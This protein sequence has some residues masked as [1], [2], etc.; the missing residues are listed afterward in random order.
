[1]NALG[2]CSPRN[3]IWPVKNLSAGDQ[4]RT[5]YADALSLSL[6]HLMRCETVRSINDSGRR[7]SDQLARWISQCD[8]IRGTC[9]ANPLSAII[10]AISSWT[11]EGSPRPRLPIGFPE[12]PS[13]LPPLPVGMPSN[14]RVRLVQTK[15]GCKILPK[16]V[17]EALEMGLQPII[18]LNMYE[19]LHQKLLHTIQSSTLNV[20]LEE[21]D[22]GA[23]RQIIEDLMS[24]SMQGMTFALALLEQQTLPG[25]KCLFGRHTFSVSDL[26]VLD[27]CHCGIQFLWVD[28][29]GLAEAIKQ[30]S[31][32]SAMLQKLDISKQKSNN[33]A[34]ILRDNK[35]STVDQLEAYGAK[36][37]PALMSFLQNKIGMNQKE[38]NAIKLL[39]ERKKDHIQQL[40]LF[41][42]LLTSVPL[43]K[44][45]TI[46][47]ISDMA[48]IANCESFREKQPIVHQGETGRRFYVILEGHVT[49]HITGVG[50]VADLGP[51]KFFGEIALLKD[52]PR[53]AT[54]IAHNNGPV[55]C[56]CMTIEREAFAQAREIASENA[57]K[58]ARLATAQK[59]CQELLSSFNCEG[60]TIRA[61]LQYRDLG[62]V[63]T[64][65]V[66]MFGNE[67]GYGCM[68]TDSGFSFDGLWQDGLPC[69]AGRFESAS[70]P[71]QSDQQWVR[72]FPDNAVS[73]FGFCD[74]EDSTSC[75][76]S[77]FQYALCHMHGLGVPKDETKAM[78]ILQK[79]HSIGH[80]DSSFLIA[81]SLE[82]LENDGHND[83]QASHA[84]AFQIFSSTALKGH[85][86]S[87]YRAALCLDSGRGVTKNE[88]EA[89]ALL[90]PL[91]SQGH[92]AAQYHVGVYYECG[93][94]VR[95]DYGKCMRWLKWSSQQ[96][97]FPA[98]RRLS[99][100]NALYPQG[101]AV[102]PEDDD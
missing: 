38:M 23:T 4:R 46:D 55:K 19:S 84:Q 65:T 40:N 63:Y 81:C 100:V 73:V 28:V 72:G 39:M 79:L 64:G 83:F 20:H 35:V 101:N 31:D 92:A 42:D 6:V 7:N 90:L 12:F 80:C 71:D 30:R 18:I 57:A 16:E 59:R 77:L 51:K 13:A 78:Q 45:N 32:L 102:W 86:P 2:G 41:A 47:E 29:I 36:N 8:Q 48:K 68:H 24:G 82:S 50:Q 60:I 14:L 54:C 21:A 25:V 89:F 53:N 61:L 3:S 69:G 88:R 22:F 98:T 96:N 97:Y 49:V 10:F 56:K 95:P 75:P 44:G 62:A 67:L 34:V 52:A 87:Q 43:F 94:G 91:A 1:M 11:C 17:V 74:S 76:A 33:Y 37:I 26:S 66:D 15:I 9:T 85:I 27:P 70:C 93:F 58:K 5:S 99:V